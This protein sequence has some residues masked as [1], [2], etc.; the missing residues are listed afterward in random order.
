MALVAS[1]TFPNQRTQ[2]QVIN[3][4]LSGE[5]ELA[6]SVRFNCNRGSIRKILG[7]QRIVRRSGSE[8]NFL[9]MERLT[10]PKRCDLTKKARHARLKNL[11]SASING[12]S[13]PAVGL[14]Y[15]YVLKLLQVIGIPFECQK[16]F[17][18]YYLDFLVNNIAIEVDYRPKLGVSIRRVRFKYLLKR[19]KTIY[20]V[21]SG[22]E[23][24]Q[25]NRRK[26]VSHLK[27][28]GGNPPTTA[29]YWVIRCSLDR[30]I[31]YQEGNEVSVKRRTKYSQA[32]IDWSG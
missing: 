4:Y 24:L 29:K 5:S 15:Q 25:R 6:L 31:G 17:G 21:H 10:S 3:L 19:L 2:N 20:I 23:S 28:L 13:H 32:P 30:G 18:P 22:I 9:R 1:R 12:V 8:A 14:G 26:L 11:R 7:G 27:V 16:E